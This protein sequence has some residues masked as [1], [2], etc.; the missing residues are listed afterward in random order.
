MYWWSY[1]SRIV[2][3]ILLPMY[4]GCAAIDGSMYA[5]LYKQSNNFI[6]GR[7]FW[8]G[9]LGLVAFISAS[10]C[11]EPRSVNAAPAYLDIHP[12]TFNKVLVTLY[13]VVLL[14]YAIFLMP[15]VSH[16]A[17][18][19][20]LANG[21]KTAMYDLRETLN[22]I[23]GVTTLVCLQSLCVTLHV[24]YARFTGYAAPR[25]YR[26]LLVLLTIACV[27]RSWLWS[28]RMALM[29]LILPAVIMS[30]AAIDNGKKRWL[31]LAPLAGFAG[32]FM[33]FSVGEY[34]RSWQYYQNM[35]NGNFIEF[36]W[37]RFIGYFAT[38]INNGATLVHFCDF[39]YMPVNTAAWFYTFP[40]WQM[41]GITFPPL[42]VYDT[43]ETLTVIMMH[44]NIEFN[45]PG[46]IYIPFIDYGIVGGTLCWAVLGNL[47]GRLMRRFASGNPI[48]LLLYPVWF[49][50]VLELLRIFY[51]GNGRFFPVIVAAFIITL[52]V[53]D[54]RTPPVNQDI[55][56]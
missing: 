26:I 38:S 13:G 40:V 16:P 6:T 9:L 29:E 45:N 23:P 1:P 33:L 39:L 28:E 7:E 47:S 21:S 27:L 15:V 11:A 2:A 37:V 35:W 20:E 48:G 55:S 3:F 14:C 53:K 36:A 4:L 43:P 24:G 17:L 10:W 31:A 42:M 22:R 52:Y 41:L 8:M 32:V 34:F 5:M 44:G 18:V 46:G 49:I 19:M 30:A 51:W 25:R 54:K 12:L 50:G 56:T